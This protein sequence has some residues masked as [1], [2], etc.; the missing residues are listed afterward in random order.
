MPSPFANI[1][2]QT[3]AEVHSGVEAVSHADL[4]ALIRA[5]TT[6]RAVFVTGQGRTGLVARGF[7]MRLAQLGKPAHVVAETTVP[8]IAQTDV[9]VACSGSGETM[10]TCGYAERSRK[11]GA[12]VVAVTGRPGSRLTQTADLVV[13]LPTPTSLQ[14]GNSR[15]EQSLW[16]VF[17][18]VAIAYAAYHRI[19]YE[20]VWER[21]AN[22]E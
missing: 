16:L 14:L 8:P 5:L 1:I 2:Q 12:S 9:L 3:L 20:A 4:E 11:L 19:P 7:A 18:A 6:A 10:V 13:H 15:F 22:L 17:D 21:H